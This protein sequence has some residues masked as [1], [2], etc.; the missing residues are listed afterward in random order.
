MRYILNSA[1]ASVLLAGAVSAQDL[2]IPTV[3]DQ[4]PQTTYARVKEL[5][6]DKKIVLDVN[7]APDKTFDLT[8]RSGTVTIAKELKVGDPVRVIERWVDGKRVVEIAYHS[9]EGV[10]HGDKNPEADRARATDRRPGQEVTYGR[11]KEFTDGR[12]VVVHVD[13]APDKTFDLR[14]G[15]LKVGLP[16][17]L[18]VGDQVKIVERTVHHVDIERHSGKDEKQESDRKK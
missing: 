9:G 8:N 15:S 5:T 6:P 13:N 10:A 11:V 2:P 4:G 7:N 17:G 16:K 18:K 12:K 14:D 1:L 3:R